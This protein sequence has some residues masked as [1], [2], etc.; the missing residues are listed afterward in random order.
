MI[1]V[2][3]GND[4][5]KIRY[6]K[7]LQTILLDD[8]ELAPFYA[9]VARKEIGAIGKAFGSKFHVVLKVG[10]PETSNTSLS[11]AKTKAEASTEGGHSRYKEMQLSPTKRFSAVSVTGSAWRRSMTDM[12]SFVKH[13]SEELDSGLRTLHRAL[14]NTIA[15][16]GSGSRGRVSSVTTTTVVITNKADMFKFRVGMEIRVAAAESS[17][18]LRTGTGRITHVARHSKTL[19]VTG[20]DPSAQSWQLNDYIFAVG[21]FSASTLTNWLGVGF[22]IPETV[23]SAGST[24][25]SGIDRSSGPELH[26]H[27]FDCS[28]EED[29][30]DA[31][32]A[33]AADFHD[34]GM[35]GSGVAIYLNP[36]DMGKISKILQLAKRGDL[37]AGAGG[38]GEVIARVGYST[39][40]LS[41][42]L[43]NLPIISDRTMPQGKAYF[44][45]R[46]SWCVAYVG[47]EV[48]APIDEDGLI[49]RKGSGDQF[50]AEM[51][52]ESQL[53]CMRPGENGLAYGLP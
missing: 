9:D 42:A 43:G 11:D 16:T 29:I 10:D 4:A 38:K 44:L 30:V 12:Q 52:S 21:D 23:P 32:Q 39:V 34:A 15:G 1:D 28:G 3:A 45:K 2:S 17:G 25:A 19:T 7:G 40:V 18:A 13:N 41:C 33:A 53:I 37:Q 20:V 49:Y 24:D 5:L 35:P 22:W 50:T 48:V 36:L 47:K 51:V 26:G 8:E 31:L 46:S 6:A 27:R 14:S